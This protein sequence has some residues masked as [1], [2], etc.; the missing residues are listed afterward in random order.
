MT[1]NDEIISLKKTVI[2]QKRLIA[3]LEGD[4]KSAGTFELSE[5]L[6]QQK[7]S[8]EFDLAQL[9]K[10]LAFA[11]QQALEE[12]H[13]LAVKVYEKRL[14]EYTAQVGELHKLEA[15]LVANLVKL[16]QQFTEHFRD[17]P[18]LKEIYRRLSSDARDLKVDEEIKFP[19]GD[20]NAVRHLERLVK[21]AGSGGYVTAILSLPFDPNIRGP[22][23]ER[24]L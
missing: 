16:D 11:E 10:E 13:A 15:E 8:A 22:W 1:M 20:D 3:Q 2:E 14:A 5:K 24:G 4:L 12:V 23:I 18:R 6:T 9:T 21:K 7:R 19:G 17:C